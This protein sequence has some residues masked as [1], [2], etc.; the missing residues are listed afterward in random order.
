VIGKGA[1][2]VAR[3]NQNRFGNKKEAFSPFSGDK[4]LSLFYLNAK[5]NS[6][7]VKALRI[8]NITMSVVFDPTAPGFIKI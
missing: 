2:S 3:H 4:L 5:D 1:A 7:I 6:T 8:T